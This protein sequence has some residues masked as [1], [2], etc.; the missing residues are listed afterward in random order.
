MVI[1]SIIL[2][3]WRE[4]GRIGR[5]SIIATEFVLGVNGRRADIAVLSDQFFGIEIKSDY[6]SVVRLRDQIEV[7]GRCFDRVSV[8]TGQ[9]NAEYCLSTLAPSVEIWCVD[10]QCVPSLLR[11]A[12]AVPITDTISMLQL[13]TVKQLRRLTSISTQGASR[14]H[15]LQVAQDLPR[16]VIYGAVIEQ[17]YGAYA[18]TSGA[19]WKLV[20]RRKVSL[21]HVKQLSRFAKTR[22]RIETE[23]ANKTKFWEDWRSTAS[24]IFSEKLESECTEHKS[25]NQSIQSPYHERPHQVGYANEY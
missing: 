19:F 9:K 14:S 24:S 7:Y 8:V 5:S 12:Q 23:R 6:D 11:D 17:F 4:I 20:G 21:E 3:H 25:V 18:T 15:L 16:D 22:A 2:Q 10:Q 1:K 13:L